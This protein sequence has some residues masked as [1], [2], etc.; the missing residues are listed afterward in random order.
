MTAWS[1]EKETGGC[2]YTDLRSFCCRDERWM[3][4]AERGVRLSKFL[5]ATLKHMFML[6]GKCMVA[7][8]SVN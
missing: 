4:L 2:H 6:L 7:A 3:K 1:I 5:M 8:F